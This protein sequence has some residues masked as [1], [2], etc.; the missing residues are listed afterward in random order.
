MNCISWNIRGL[1]S[2][3]RKYVVK[4][5]LKMHK[6]IDILMLQEI[7]LVQFTL[8]INLKCIWTDSV[9]FVTK[10][11]KGRGGVAILI[12][13]EWAKMIKRWHSSPCNK[14]VWIIP[15]FKEQ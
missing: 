4:R 8:D 13:K 7:K 11:S 3:D 15:S 14:D 5:F 1:E 10:Y 9:Q 12:S 2:L 6:N